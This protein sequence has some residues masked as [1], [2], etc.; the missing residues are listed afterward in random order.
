[1]IS[2]TKL[3][4]TTKCNKLLIIG[5]L[6]MHFRQSVLQSIKIRHAIENIFRAVTYKFSDKILTYN[7]KY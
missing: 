5:Q 1:M 7:I 6:K 2:K 4:L 3:T